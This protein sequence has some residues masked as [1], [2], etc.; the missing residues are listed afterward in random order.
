[1]S[2]WS[3]ACAPPKYLLVL[4]WGVHFY[5]SLG[6][7]VAMSISYLL[8]QEGVESFRWVFLLMMLGIF[9]DA[10]DG[11][12]ARLVNV[13]EVV[14]TFDGRR[15]DDL[16]DF[17]NYTCLP[18]FL[19]W[20]AELLPAPHSWWLL[21]PL[22]ASA[23]G[24]CQTSAKTEDGYFLGFPSYWNVVAFYLYVLHP[25][26]WVTLV[27]LLG[28]AVLTFVPLRYLYPTQ[29]GPLNR[30]TVLF[31]MVWIAT[32]IAVLFLLPPDHPAPHHPRSGLLGWLTLL[33]L[34]FPA[35]YLIASWVISYR[36]WRRRRTRA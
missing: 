27:L 36:C 5:T 7:V 15:L 6:L 16:I 33:S 23:Y 34:T 1:M 31:S 32:P 30:F 26:P 20:R 9:I 35:Y 4:A 13:K 24:F 29:P 25:A 18:L 21:A 12:L 11:T 3:P 17:L 2:T 22:L 10:T 28:F 8:V 14:P 19:I